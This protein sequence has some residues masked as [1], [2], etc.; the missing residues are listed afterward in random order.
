MVRLLI[1]LG[2][3]VSA[4]FGCTSEKA[5]VAIAPATGFSYEKVSYPE[6]LRVTTDASPARNGEVSFSFGEF[7]LRS[8]DQ[9]LTPSASPN[10]VRRQQ[11]L[12]FEGTIRVEEPIKAGALTT[13][14][15]L[16]NDRQVPTILPTSRGQPKETQFH[17]TLCTGFGVAGKG[18]GDGLLKYK[19]QLNA[20][21]AVGLFRTEI[22][23][24]HPQTSFVKKVIA[25]F[26]LRV[27]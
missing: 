3:I 7:D 21:D 26:D 8:S 2:V 17:S 14:K 22:S 19:V 4:S 11:P 5:G 18:S 15:V 10:S 12:V 6:T 16:G 24:L 20:P 9:P 1:A 27:D 23:V 13:V 25:K